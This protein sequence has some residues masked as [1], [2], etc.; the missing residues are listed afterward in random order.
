MQLAMQQFRSLEGKIRINFGTTSMIVNPLTQ[1]RI[2]LDHIALEA[3]IILAGAAMP[4]VPALP[5]AGIGLAA[6][7][8][9]QS[10]ILK[11]E[12]LG[13][14]LIEGHEAIG[15]RYLFPPGGLI[16]S[17]E[18]WTSTTLQLPVLTRT[19]GSFGEKICACKCTPVPPPPSLF[20]IP[21][22]YK[23]IRPAAG[24]NVVISP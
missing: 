23:V 10:A 15:M 17:W 8:A 16:F 13:I 12:Q 5:S 20:E 7:F 4:A 14:A 24:V 9:L 11:I 1:V 3:R 2:L 18:I 19:I 6:E 22:G 21:P